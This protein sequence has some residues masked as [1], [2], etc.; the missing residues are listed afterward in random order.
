[1]ADAVRRWCD[2]PIQRFLAQAEQFEA[3]A[4][5]QAKRC[6]G[7]RQRQHFK[8]RCRARG[9]SEEAIAAAIQMRIETSPS[10]CANKRKRDPV[11]S[12]TKSLSQLSLSEGRSK[13]IKPSP[14]SS[15]HVPLQWHT[16][17]KY[18]KMPRRRLMHSLHLQLNCALKKKSE[19]NFILAR[20][21]WID[22][23]FCLEQTRYLYRIYVELAI[24]E[25]NDHVQSDVRVLDRDIDRCST[26]LNE[27]WSSCPW[28]SHPV[29]DTMDARLKEFVRLHHIDLLRRTSYQVHRFKDE[30]NEQ[31][32]L[33]QLSSFQFTGEQVMLVDPLRQRVCIC[34]D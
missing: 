8:R 34:L 5:A 21:Q 28:T 11:S 9:W 27:Q 16:L 3:K 17:S 1:M 29:V 31:H 24:A 2:S 13:K 32:L 14:F 23:Q 19:Q 10:K 22:R 25:T 12:S 15:D 7:N 26:A 6:H 18:L 30:I 33:R 20:L 4:K